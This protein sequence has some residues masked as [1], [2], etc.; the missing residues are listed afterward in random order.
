MPCSALSDLEDTHKYLFAY[1]KV[2]FEVYVLYSFGELAQI[3]SFGK[4]SECLL[5]SNNELWS[6]DLA[7]IYCV[8][9]K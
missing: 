4:N 9:N 7:Q 3:L 1:F 5:C 2:H 6:G 8:S